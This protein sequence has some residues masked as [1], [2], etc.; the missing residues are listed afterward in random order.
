MA[1]YETVFYPYEISTG[2]SIDACLLKTAL[3][4]PARK[5]DKRHTIFVTHEIVLL[6][7]QERH[8]PHPTN[9]L[10]RRLR[11]TTLGFHI[12]MMLLPNTGNGDH[13]TRG[14]DAPARNC[15]TSAQ[16]F[17]YIH[18]PVFFYF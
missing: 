11:Y 3:Y 7:V 2:A 1:A 5:D 4:T 9:L 18:C 12:V 14:N 8:V 16:I 10:I 6:T 13:K 17:L 15:I